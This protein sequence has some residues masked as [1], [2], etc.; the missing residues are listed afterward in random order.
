MVFLGILRGLMPNVWLCGE[1]G[2]VAGA[3]PVE[4][5]S[6]PP[7]VQANEVEGDGRADVFEAGGV[8]Q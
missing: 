5:A 1:V 3:G 4:G 6:V 2:E 8:G 7:G